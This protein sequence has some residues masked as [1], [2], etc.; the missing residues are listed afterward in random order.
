ML[1]DLLA[2]LPAP[3][4][5]VCKGLIGAMKKNCEDTQQLI[6]GGNPSQDPAGTPTTAAAITDPLGAIAHGCA[7][8]AQWVIDHL[9]DAISKTATVDFTNLGSWASTGS[10]SR[11]RP[12]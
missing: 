12:S 8:A 6:T 2:A 11:P 4:D 5:P 7:Q 1:R 9:S 3:T 10:C